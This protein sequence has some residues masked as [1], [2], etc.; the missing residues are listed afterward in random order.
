[1]AAAPMTLAR[2]LWESA[3]CCP[4]GGGKTRVARNAQGGTGCLQGVARCL[5]TLFGPGGGETQSAASAAEDGSNRCSKRK[6][7]RSS[8]S[9]KTSASKA[10][11]VAEECRLK[12]HIRG[13]AEN[14][15][16]N[17]CKGS[18]CPA[19]EV[20]GSILCQSSNRVI[21]HGPK[22]RC[23]CSVVAGI[24]AQPIYIYIYLFRY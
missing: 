17:H 21:A 16:L 10:P 14:Q 3:V 12:L 8:R 23:T 19:N 9:S 5:Q 1:M 15:I 4:A 7:S 22:G 24:V 6:R 20:S 13:P 18:L 2:Q 11:C